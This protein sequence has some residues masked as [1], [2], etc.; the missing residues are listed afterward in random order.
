MVCKRYFVSNMAISE[1]KAFQITINKKIKSPPAS[2]KTCGPMRRGACAPASLV[3]IIAWFQWPWS[4]RKEKLIYTHENQHTLWQTNIAMEYLI[5]NRKYILKGSIFHC[6]VSLPECNLPK[7]DHFKRTFHLPT[8]NFQGIF[9]SFQ[10]GKY[11]F[12]Q[13]NAAMEVHHLRLRD[14]NTSLNG[15][16]FYCKNP[17]P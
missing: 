13:S 6:Y 16:M 10:G 14:T 7:R 15:W 17:S 4:L 5:F 8:I 3:C 12:W 9:V 1:D 2:P 11:T